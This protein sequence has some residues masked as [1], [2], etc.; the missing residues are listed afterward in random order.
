M[1][2]RDDPSFY[3]DRTVKYDRVI[4]AE[5]NAVMFCRDPLPL[6]GFVLYTT[7]PC[8]SR[9]MVHMIQCGI[10]R[11]AWPKEYPRELDERWSVSETRK[12]MAEVGAEL[13]EV[14]EVP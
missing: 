5:M 8:C 12:H 3:E 7:G 2:M 14:E 9:C 11:F 6:T 13:I 4:H 1:S 10:R